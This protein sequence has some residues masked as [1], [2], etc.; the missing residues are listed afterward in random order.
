MSEQHLLRQ[1]ESRAL[2]KR[3]NSIICTQKSTNTYTHCSVNLSF[4]MQLDVV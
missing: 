2:T 3:H 4:S 1:N